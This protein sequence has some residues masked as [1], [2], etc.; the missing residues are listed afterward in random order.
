AVNQATTL[1]QP[2]Q[3]VNPTATNP[4]AQTANPATAIPGAENATTVFITNNAANAATPLTPPEGAKVFKLQEVDNNFNPT[5]E[6]G[7]YYDLN[8]DG[9][10]DHNEV[11]TQD[12]QGNA[13]DPNSPEYQEKMA[14]YGQEEILTDLDG[15]GSLSADEYLHQDGKG[16]KIA[17]Q[18]GFDGRLQALQQFNPNLQPTS[19]VF[20]PNIFQA[21]ANG[22]V[23]T[24]A[25]QTPEQLQ[26]SAQQMIQSYLAQP[27]ADQTKA[28]QLLAE[29]NQAIT[30]DPVG[31]QAALTNL[32]QQLGVQVP[33]AQPADPLA[34]TAAN[35]TAPAVTANPTV[36]TVA[37]DPANNPLINAVNTALPADNAQPTIT[38]NAQANDPTRIGQGLNLL[39]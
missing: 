26:Q 25:N 3:N 31:G 5:G 38:T 21:G 8:G 7:T 19:N 34:P 1:G 15:N 27:N 16:G 35:A 28:D 14:K 9:M 36:P 18:A 11:M 32:S 6:L 24:A 37:T 39:V 12:G 22:L 33:A 17:D 23:A 30:A 29:F 13:L 4:L 10:L 2:V 20:N